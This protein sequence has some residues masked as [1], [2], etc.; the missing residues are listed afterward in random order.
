MVAAQVPCKQEMLN[1]G[2]SQGSQEEGVGGSG[3]SQALPGQ[4]AF[5]VF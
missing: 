3:S 2:T 4:T 1:A 5:R